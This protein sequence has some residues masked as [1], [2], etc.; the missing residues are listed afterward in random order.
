VSGEP[1]WNFLG[2]VPENY[3]RYLVP[4]IFAPWA[5]DLI[6]TAALLPGERVLDVA[7][8]TGI[9]ARIAARMLGTNGSVSGLDASSPM[10]AAARAA[11]TAE[12]VV[13][14][15]R[16]GSALALPFA[17]AAFDAVLCQQGLQF[18]PERER[19]LREMNRVLRP[20]G[21]LVLS[22]WGPIERSLGFAALADA[23]THHISPEAGALLSAGPFCLSDADQ[24]RALVAD[25]GFKDIAVRRAV[26]IL[27][28]Q[29]ADEFV[30]RYT[31]SSSL[32][33]VVHGADKGARTALIA[34]VA[35]KLEPS[36]NDRH[37][38]FPIETN[39]AFA[40]R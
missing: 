20:G 23:L 1:N 2:S 40:R 14:E 25:A 16:E 32:A 22:V 5:S 38:E 6:E 4:S 8:G 17:E 34:E 15:W 26:K 36:G 35:E 18:F 3:E 39:V 10:I 19:A 24:L 13:V 29:S 30:L 11:A 21:R 7:C 37:L 12:G 9:V 31:V 28:Y 33:S 27:H